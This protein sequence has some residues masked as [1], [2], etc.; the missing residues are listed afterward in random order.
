[1]KTASAKCLVT[2]GRIAFGQSAITCLCA[3][4]L[5]LLTDWTPKR[6]MNGAGPSRCCSKSEPRFMDQR[7]GLQS[8]SRSRGGHSVCSEPPQ[9]L[10][11]KRQELIGCQRLFRVERLDRLLRAGHARNATKAPRIWKTWEAV[12]QF[13]A[14][15]FAPYRLRRSLRNARHHPT[16]VDRSCWTVRHDALDGCA[17]GGQRRINASAPGPRTAL[18]GLLVSHLRPRAPKWPLAP[19]CPS[20]DRESRKQKENLDLDTSR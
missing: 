12:A 10:A 15:S 6:S 16:R 13:L 1:M 18:S 2:N 20:V 8:L 3:N 5:N 17:S 7:G 4:A 19:R 9:F 14:R 11:H